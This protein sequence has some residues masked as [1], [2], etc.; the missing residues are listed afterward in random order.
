MP[1]INFYGSGAGKRR[2]F[3][4]SNP[5]MNGF[6]PVCKARRSAEAPGSVHGVTNLDEMQDVPVRNIFERLPG[7]DKVEAGNTGGGAAKCFYCSDNFSK[8]HYCHQC[9]SMENAGDAGAGEESMEDD[10]GAM[11][12]SEKQPQPVK[13]VAFDSSCTRSQV[14]ESGFLINKQIQYDM[15]L[16]RNY[17]FY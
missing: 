7:R 12:T 3:D 10:S 14:V 6:R 17:V 1:N 11:D 4:D 5:D 2:A 15:M 13:T 8:C 9:P 16:R